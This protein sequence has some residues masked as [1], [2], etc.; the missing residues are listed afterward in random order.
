MYEQAKFEEKK[1]TPILQVIDRAIPPVKRAYPARSLMAGAIS[2]T[3]VCVALIVIIIREY[4]R[5]S[6]NPRL[7]LVLAELRRKRSGA[8]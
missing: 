3:S 1:E 7:A 2:L 8:P 5:H 6:S 4:L